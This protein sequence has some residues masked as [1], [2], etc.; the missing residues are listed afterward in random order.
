MPACVGGGGFLLSTSAGGMASSANRS[1]NARRSC[2]AVWIIPTPGADSVP[3]RGGRHAI[4][5]SQNSTCSIE[6]RLDR[7]G[8]VRLADVLVELGA[9]HHA[10]GLIAHTAENQGA[11]AGVQ[12]IGEVLQRVEP[13][14]VDRGHI[15]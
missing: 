9:L 11:T 14:A 5:V 10:C 6:G 1:V 2:F 3:S 7:R 8:D 12:D 13:G 4:V 15:A